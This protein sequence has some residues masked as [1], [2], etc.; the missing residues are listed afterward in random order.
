MSQLWPEDISA[1]TIS[2]ALKKIGFT[3]PCGQKNRK[4]KLTAIEKEM[5]KKEKNG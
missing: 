3:L 4:K 1:R 2:R 5:T